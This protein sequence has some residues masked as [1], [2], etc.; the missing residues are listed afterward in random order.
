MNKAHVVNLET[1]T[2]N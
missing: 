2:I 1:G